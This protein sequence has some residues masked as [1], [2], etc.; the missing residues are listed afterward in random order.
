[1]VSRP[2]L[3]EDAQ[4]DLAVVCTICTSL[5]RL[6]GFGEREDG[7]DRRVQ[8]AVVSEQGEFGELLAVGLDDEVVS[9][10]LVF[11]RVA[12]G[13]GDRDEPTSGSHHGG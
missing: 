12:R 9:G 3:V 6:A 4:D 10:D 2:V 1:M 13:P 8:V 7:V 11:V 5:E